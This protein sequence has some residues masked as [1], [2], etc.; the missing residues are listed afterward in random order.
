[1]STQTPSVF[2]IGK[3]GIT[4][5]KKAELDAL[6]LKVL[7]EQHQVE[8]FQAI[9]T[10]LTDK[11]EKFQAFLMAAE[12][13]RAQALSNKNLMDE[14]VQNAL[15]LQKNSKIAYNEMVAADS[16]TKILA[17]TV[18]SVMNELIYAAEVINRL[19]NMVI[20]KKD[21]NPLISDE[22]MSMI[23]TAG[24]DANNAVALTLVAL[25]STFAAQASSMESQAAAGLEYPQSIKLY[26]L[27]TFKGSAATKEQSI[28][29]L[30][31][32]AY[33]TA[34]TDFISAKKASQTTIDQLNIA[35]TQLGKA[36]VWYNSLSSGLSAGNAAALAS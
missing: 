29:E 20:R 10:A 21:Q 13:N 1:M 25:K 19:A 8:Q 22:L 30:L 17:I 28:Q 15:G 3:Y 7:D 2:N 31:D 16:Q 4:E 27:L 18:R 14:V 24:K 9:V 5:K 12:A 11:S 35:K 33:D 32:S 23:A 36:Q 6:T 34:K 26:N